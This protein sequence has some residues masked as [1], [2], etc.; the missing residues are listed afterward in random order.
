MS[1][2]NKQQIQLRSLKDEKERLLAARKADKEAFDKKGLQ[3]RLD[4]VA[5]E[6][7]DLEEQLE[8]EEQSEHEES[9]EQNEVKK[10]KYVPAKGTEKML[11]LKIVRRGR[12]YNPDTGKEE[13]K[14]ST[15]LF[16][17]GEWQLFK[18][19]HSR[20]GYIIVE[21]VYD[22]YDEAQKFVQQ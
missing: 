18:E 11:C 8:Y 4:K 3:S 2:K 5:E 7:I 1:E 13:R 19:N 22:P 12:R 15:Q 20:L 6:I 9:K 16:T 10:G 21:V 14:P 17:Y